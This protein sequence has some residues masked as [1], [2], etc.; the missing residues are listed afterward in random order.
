MVAV[1]GWWALAVFAVLAPMLGCASGSSSDGSSTSSTT[2][3]SAVPVGGE[4]SSDVPA[5]NPGGSGEVSEDAPRAN[6]TA[7]D[8]G[9]VEGLSVDP[10]DLDVLELP[11]GFTA[12][13][14]GWQVSVADGVV[15]DP[16]VVSLPGDAPPEGMIPVLLHR[17]DTG[18]FEPDPAEYT[19]G[20]YVADVSSFSPRLPGWLDP[21]EWLDSGFDYLSGR[22][23][24]PEPCGTEPY[25]WAVSAGSPPDGSFHG[26]LNDNPKSDGTERVEVKIKSNRD[27][28]MW[29]TLPDEPHDF[30]WIEGLG[31]WTFIAPVINELDQ[32]FGKSRVLLP[33][34]R[35]VTIGY[36]RPVGAGPRLE[37]S[38][39]QNNTTQLVSLA[40]KYLG[41]SGTMGATVAMLWCYTDLLARTGD[42][43]RFGDISLD[44]VASCVA[45]SA[46]EA[47]ELG[48]QLLGQIQ[49]RYDNLIEQ[50]RWQLSQGATANIEQL[51]GTAGG[52]DA[53]LTS[54][55]SSA[56][57]GLGSILAA[58][59]A[60]ELL[61]QMSSMLSDAILAFTPGL[62]TF[63]VHLV[64]SADGDDT[65]QPDELSDVAP[66]VVV[67]SS[68]G[69]TQFLAYD[70]PQLGRTTISI[71]YAEVS[72]EY[73]PTNATVR[74]VVDG[75]GT[76]VFEWT[77]PTD[78]YD[79]FGFA[80]PPSEA[81]SPV[82]GRGHVFFGYNPG[83]FPGISY[84][85][86]TTTGF[87]PRGT[88]GNY[89]DGHYYASL[90]DIDDDGLYEIE[91]GFQ[92]CQPDCAGG[93]YYS[94]TWTWDGTGYSGASDPPRD[95]S[96]TSSQP[97]DD[98]GGPPGDIAEQLFVDYLLA[99]GARDYEAA[100]N[101]LTPWYQSDYGG[102]DRFV[103]FWSGISLV[104]VDTIEPIL[105]EGETHLE[106]Q[107]WYQD[108]SGDRQRERVQVTVIDLDGLGPSISD[109]HFIE[110]LD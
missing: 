2:D 1:R 37:F 4:A 63:T 58:V 12:A 10:I 7:A 105:G 60:A 17:T 101:M 52:L 9:E 50:G 107:L 103:D 51:I 44:D 66:G 62:N 88:L 18:G 27:M 35:T 36:T 108:L 99:A 21:G 69:L 24:P 54:R 86:P 23:D 13:G 33:P 46:A 102:F 90:T 77:S 48:D 14:P 29:I 30:V 84:L 72:S 15:G 32:A 89:D 40:H 87:D 110:V 6:I 64:G 94:H 20:S 97:Q 73:Q 80:E 100:W 19:E 75:T 43:T 8:G 78:E 39:Y 71:S 38:S 16:L 93:T 74:A 85:V 98:S 65:S 55:L 34:G 83:R 28:A 96:T 53:T 109:Y 42:D 25:G 92:I 11:D 56:I 31:D 91:Q 59:R 106:V 79:V 70:H 95:D 49:G 3:G 26:C 45:Q 104:G 68:D 61:S 41:E 47:L 82:D 81:R 76:T 5:S 67:T 22:T 57:R